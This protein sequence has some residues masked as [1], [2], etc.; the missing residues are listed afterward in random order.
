MI[1]QT[2]P[3]STAF[4]QPSNTISSRRLRKASLMLGLS[5]AAWLLAWEA[6]RL[7]MVGAPLPRADAIAVLSGSGTIRERVRRAADLY[8]E[9]LAPKIILTNDNQ[10]AGWSAAEQRNPFYYQIAEQDLRSFGVPSAVI[11]IIPQ[12]VTSTHEEAS[13]LRRYAEDHRLNS[14]LVVTSAYH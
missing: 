14:I 9:G 8:K 12:P 4:P 11:E 1:H 10:Q 13:L 6:A 3:V 7:L 2:P 5:L